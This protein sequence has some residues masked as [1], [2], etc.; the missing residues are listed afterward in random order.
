MNN[1]ITITDDF[2]EE[3]FTGR[4]KDYYSE[5]INNNEYENFCRVDDII[6]RRNIIIN[7]WIHVCTSNTWKS[8]L[9]EIIRNEQYFTKTLKQVENKFRKYFDDIIR[10]RKDNKGKFSWKFVCKCY[11]DKDG[12]CY[13]YATEG[14]YCKKDQ[15][16]IPTKKEKII[17]E[18]SIAK[19]EKIIVEQSTVIKK[20]TIYQT[21]GYQISQQLDKE[22]YFNLP[23]GVN[24]TEG[25][26]KKINTIGDVNNKNK[27]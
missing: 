16:F 12:Q 10:Y 22:N 25:L 24:A 15:S 3:Y 13:S 6:Y 18:Q 4:F 1:L 27:K 23:I 11:T 14:I 19:K 2:K 5:I 9:E 7:K 8:Y 21:E 26:N 20:E 17:V